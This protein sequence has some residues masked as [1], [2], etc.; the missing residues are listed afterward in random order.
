M[1]LD[2]RMSKNTRKRARYII[3]ID[4][5]T[6]NSAVAYIDTRKYP[7]GGPD[8]VQVFRLPQLVGE[9]EITNRQGLPSFLYLASGPELP[10]GSL[11]LPWARGR[12]LAV[13]EF[14]RLQGSKVHGRLIS[15]AKS[16]LC[17]EGVD[18]RAPILPWGDVRDV[19]RRSP[20]EASALYLSHMKDAWNHEM[21]GDSAANAFEKQELVITVP[22][23]FDEVAR[24]LTL[25]AAEKAGLGD[26]TLLEEPQAAFYSWI[27]RHETEWDRLAGPGTVVLVCDIG[28]GTTDFT[29]ISVKE[30]ENGPVPERIAV[31]EHLLLGGDNMDL[32]LARLV[33]SRMMGSDEKRLDSRHWHILT[34]LCRRAKERFLGTHGPET[35]PIALPG[36]GRGVVAG[37]LSSALEREDVEK[38]IVNGFFPLTGPDELPVRSTSMGIQEFGL[39]FDPDPVIPHHLAAFLKNHRSKDPAAKEQSGAPCLQPTAILF[40]GGVFT[41]ESVRKRVLEILSTWFPKAGEKPWEPL[42]LDNKV[43]AIA[44]AWGAA[45]YGLV[46][47]GRGVRIVGGSPRAYY[48]KVQPRDGAEQEPGTISAVCVIPRGM[49]AGEDVEIET[50]VFKVLTNQPVSFSLYSSHVRTGD[51]LGDIAGLSE[52]EVSRLPLLKTVLRFGKKGVVRKIPVYLCARLTEIGTLEVACHAR[53]TDHRWKLPFNIRPYL[54]ENGGGDKPAGKSRPALSEEQTGEAL[55]LLHA[56]FGSEKPAGPDPVTPETVVKRLLKAAGFRKERWPLPLLRR[57]ADDLVKEPG[58]RKKSARHEERWLNLTGFCLRPGYGFTGDDYRMRQIWKLYHEG[59]A[60]P[61]DRQCRVEWW[62]LWRRV[63]GGLNQ[64]QQMTLF[65]E[66][67]PLVSPGKKKAGKQPRLSA[68]ERTEMWRAIANLEQLPSDVKENVGN[69]LVK[70]LG[71]ARGEGLNMWVLSRIGSRIPLYGPFNEVVPPKAV[72]AWINKVLESEWSKPDHTAFCVVQMASFTGD[73]GRDVDGGL[74]NRISER[75]SRLENGDRLCHRLHE[76][77]PLSE[78]EQGLVFGEGLPEG[79]HLAE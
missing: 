51:Q 10:P 21:A 72:T 55:K 64:T 6:T 46:R 38:T 76:I 59:I 14:A 42:V 45:Y 23:S 28:G 75:L 65:R 43:P 11:D 20:V 4:L 16:W 73:R 35:I 9:G 77:V 57:F 12:D 22:A 27:A 19:A 47:R 50:P 29:L 78:S 48:V 8:S 56:A 62:I 31:G 40:N 13:G 34:S 17:H 25:E 74:R 70:H 26:I 7:T 15:S 44:V 49:E 5:G 37:V 58:N 30:S 53:E 79:L 41:P 67:F 2:N 63:A 3:G 33:E 36:R 69:R 60:F 54:A 61:R 71:T 66:A 24:E 68:Q 52:D 1:A 39:P 32:A 18:R